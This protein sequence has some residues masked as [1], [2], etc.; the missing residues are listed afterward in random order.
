MIVEATEASRSAWAAVLTAGGRGAIAV[1]R[2]WGPDALAIAD[3]AFRPQRGPRLAE[4]PRGRPR[5]GRMG[6]GTGD[7][8][9][10]VVDGNPVE[11]EV[12]CHGGPSPVALVMEALT[13]LG[14]RPVRAEQWLID[15]SGSRI[16]AE[17]RID[18]VHA[19]TV[20]S[21]EVLLE[22]AQGAFRAELARLATEARL[23]ERR[24]VVAQQLNLLIERGSIGCRLISGW[25]VV[26]AG[27]PNVGKSR[28]LNALAGFERAIVDPNPGTTRDLVT[29][30]TAIRG[31]P[32]ELVDTAGLR[33]PADAIENQGI[34]LARAQQQR[35]DLVVLVLDRSEPLTEV[36]HELLA[37]LPNALVVANKADLPPAW[38][39]LDR[40]E[41]NVSAERGEGIPTLIEAIGR[42]LLP[43]PPPAGSAVP[44]R[45]WHGRW[46]ARARDQLWN[47]RHERAARLLERMGR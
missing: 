33:D 22:Q 23:S 8:V 5:L 21:A 17:A 45:D 15:A 34:G 20:F 1:I 7:E 16:E 26:L 19:P 12:Q 2:I 35:A 13:S 6:Q 25:R 43:E 10:A 29:L 18:L 47:G 40:V 14:A 46:L 32:V 36:D 39:S 27:R 38:S 4:S 37:A 41:R 42:R 30:P 31:L 9:V 11:V 44:F 28:L 24:A 3:A